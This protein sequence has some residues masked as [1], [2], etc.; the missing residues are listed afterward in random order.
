MEKDLRQELTAFIISSGNNPNFNDCIAALENQ[1]VKINIDVIKDYHPMS[2]AFQQMLIRCKTKYYVEVDED[3]ILEQN[4]I[5]TMYN[6]ISISESAIAM[7]A[8]Q[9]LDVHL[10]F[11]IFGIKIYKNEIFQKYPYNLNCLS[12]EVEQL[13]RLKKDGFNYQCIEQVVGK[14]SP[15]WL[16]KD[17]FERYYNLMEKFK[18][19]GYSWLE[20]LP[21]KL[22]NILK[23]TPTEE[24]LYALLGAYTS[25]LKNDIDKQEKNFIQNKKIEYAK[26]QSF[27]S[28]PISCTIYMTSKCNFSCNWCYRQHN[29]IEN[30]SDMDITMTRTLLNRFPS[31]RSCCICGFGEPLLS[32]NL[33]FVIQTL[34][35]KNIFIGLI[36]N[37]SL[38]EDKI[39]ELYAAQQYLPNYI[40]ISLN[41]H[42]AT[43]HQEITKTNSFKKILRGI[44][45]TIDR[46]ME[47]YVSYICTRKN[48]LYVPQFLEVVK[49]IG[50]K[51]VHLHNLL[52]HFKEEENKDFWDLVLQEND[53]R[54][55]ESIKNN[56]NSN[57]VKL[58]PTLINKDEIRRNCPFAWQTIAM[59]GNGSISICNSVYPCD[60][61]NGNINDNV[62]WQNK[63]CQDFRNSILTK[64]SSACQKCFRNWQT[65]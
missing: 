51:T 19:F 21:L 18:E 23:Q 5:E 14:H 28:Q 30:A 33:K 2:L 12:C 4:G 11:L 64:Q 62:V 15:K 63:Y 26:M 55:I 44:K 20:I 61:K 59:N 8:Y 57:I 60:A 32:V 22:W 34:K 37:G 47:T 25:I 17:I 49:N 35:E 7:I 56:S 1:T 65:Y 54:F 45:K 40:S 31:I 27:I 41:A 58:Y 39:D 53:E 29:E 50:V 38:L 3:M 42:D 46:G 6:N 52:P 43:I 36:T 48:I 13:E 24:N 9:L 16:S 10:N